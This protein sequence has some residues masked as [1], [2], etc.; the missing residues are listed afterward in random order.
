MKKEHAMAV[1]AAVM[2]LLAAATG[3]THAAPGLRVVKDPVSGELRAPTAAEAAQL[4]APSSEGKSRARTADT[5][6]RGLLTGTLNPKVVVNADGSEMLELTEDS[7]S[8]SVARRNPDGSITMECVTGLK[9]AAQAM[10]PNQRN[11]KMSK[12]HSHAADK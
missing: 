4:S 7:Q 12:D 5:G 1:S 6:S 3:A 11:A 2:T 8:Y 9:A 10:K